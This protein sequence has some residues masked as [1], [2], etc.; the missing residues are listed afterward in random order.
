KQYGT[1]LTEDQ[2]I[3]VTGSFANDSSQTLSIISK[4]G[5]VISS[6]RYYEQNTAFGIKD[7]SSG[8]SVHYAYPQNGSTNMIKYSY[9]KANRTP[10]KVDAIQVPEEKV[11]LTD[12]TNVPILND[13]T[14][15]GRVST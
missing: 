8:F 4:T 15:K 13:L 6:A 7:V 3:R 14:A 9:L 11:N 10:G 5:E 1:D 12:N 2:I